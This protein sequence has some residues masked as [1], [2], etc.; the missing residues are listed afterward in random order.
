[1]KHVLTQESE[2]IIL[3]VFHKIDISIIKNILLEC[4]LVIADKCSEPSFKK[5]VVESINHQDEERM[6]AYLFLAKKAEY[7][8]ERNHPYW[9]VKGTANRAAIMLLSNP[10][11]KYNFTTVVSAIFN[12]ASEEEKKIF[13]EKIQQLE[14]IVA[15]E[16]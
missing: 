6:T 16:V 14:F 11:E 12:G 10:T 4:F 15:Q 3:S 2:N 13:H 1:M 9:S 5:I 7:W 8:E